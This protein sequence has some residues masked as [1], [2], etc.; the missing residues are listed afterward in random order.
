MADSARAA[1]VRGDGVSALAARLRRIIRRTGPM[2]VA[3]F[4]TLAL[5]DRRHGYYG[6]AGA[7]DPFGRDGDF[8]TAPEIGQM[9]GEL[10]GAWCA[11]LWERMGAPDPVSLVE[12]GPGRGALMADLLRAAA[13]APAFRRAIRLHA[14]EISP[15]LRRIQAEALAPERPVWH[16]SLAAAPRGPALFIANEWF[17]A[18]PVHQFVGAPQ[19]WRERLVGLTE[20]GER[21][22]TGCARA[23]TPASRLLEKL[24]RAPR[25]G[26]V[27]EVSFAALALAG[28]LAERVV[29]GPGAALIVDYAGGGGRDSL[30]GTRRHRARAPLDMPGEIDLGAHVDFDALARA[31]REA[32]AA[33]WGPVGQGAFLEALGLRQR[34]AR[35][36]S[37]APQRAGEID[38][39][40]A[41]LASPDGMGVAFQALALGAP[42]G[43]VPA[44]FPP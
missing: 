42:D 5:A 18:L 20:D 24:G 35:L 22:A 11:D 4:M 32:G 27:A 6:G 30:R 37:A 38:A 7:R 43:P 33:V 23:P 14:V 29:E 13:A 28:E 25:P 40:A 19:G 34:C 3:Q 10:I 2:D 12:L 15:A 17:D 21:L 8:T 31:A 36:K 9:F 26:A 1:P 41:R 44:G 16:D 39:A